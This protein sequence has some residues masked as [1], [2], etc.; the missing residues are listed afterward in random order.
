MKDLRD[1]VLVDLTSG[2]IAVL[3]AGHAETAAASNRA[4]AL[5]ELQ[6]KDRVVNRCAESGVDVPAAW[7]AYATALRSVL[8]SGAS[9]PDRPAFPPG[10]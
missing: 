4:A 9:L 2:E 3:T 8:A 6:L 1:G 10:T 7:S 5:A